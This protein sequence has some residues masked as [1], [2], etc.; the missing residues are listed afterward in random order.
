[1]T[2]NEMREE[3]G[4]PGE[5]LGGDIPLNGVMVQRIGQ[6]MQE[7]Q[8]VY[9]RQQDNINRYM[10]ASLTNQDNSIT[11][12]EYQQGLAGNSPSVDGKDTTGD[13]GK[14]GQIASSENTNNMGQGGKDEKDE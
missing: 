2:V 5:V 7:E 6:L 9:S 4:L 8:Y 12:Q 1:M 13:V 10:E 3:I 14:D 11:F